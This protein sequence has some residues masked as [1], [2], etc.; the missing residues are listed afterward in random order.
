MSFDAKKFLKTKFT[1]RTDEVAVPAL[2]AFFPE[3]AKPLWKV[4]GLTGQELGV[5]NEAPE[6][7]RNMAAIMEGLASGAAKEQADAV[8]E[9]L[10]IGGTTPQDVAKRLEHLVVGSVD[11]KCTQELAVRLCEVFPV[12]FFQL[13]N[14]I[15]ALTG[16]GQMPGKQ[17]PSGETPKSAPAS[18]SAT[19]G[20]DSSTS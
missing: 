9:L 7:M 6:R 14:K 19:P 8:K 1:L 18:P 2:A 11:P 13:T 5:A 3:E 10:G 15:A 17:P 4:R 16:Q 12:E 20:G